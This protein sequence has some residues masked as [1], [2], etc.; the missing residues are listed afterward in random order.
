[1]IVHVVVPAKAPIRADIPAI[2]LYGPQEPAFDGT[3]LL[4]DIIEVR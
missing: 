2:R 3:W 4:G 1:M